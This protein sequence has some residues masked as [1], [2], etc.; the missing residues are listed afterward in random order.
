MRIT[1]KQ[2]RE[3]IE[4]ELKAMKEVN[5]MHDP[6]TGKF[7][8]KGKKGVYSLTKNAEDD[9]AQDSELQAPARGTSSGTGKV[10][11]KFGMSTGSPEKQCGR[12]TIDGDKKKKTRRCA[13]YPKKY[14]DKQNEETE[15]MKKKKK[16][17]ERKN[18]N[19]NKKDLVPRDN[20]SPSIRR[21]KVFPGSEEVFRLARGIA[22]EEAQRD[23]PRW[24]VETFTL[25]KPELE[26]K[27]LERDVE[28]DDAYL[29]GLIKQ[30]VFQGLQSARE[31]AAKKG[32]CYSWERIMKLIQ[33]LE[34]AQKGAPKK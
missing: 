30:A 8:G 31:E 3:M 19:K 29:K 26:L 24:N 25:E 2:I 32:Q 7:Q 15:Y 14:W 10:S 27:E 20:D 17:T 4:E 12:L 33:D 22:E 28:V 23:Y 13:D 16:E 18:Q 21:E 11:A 1:Q 6:K 5:P 9:L 34:T